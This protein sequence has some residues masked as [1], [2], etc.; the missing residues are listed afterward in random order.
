M[1]PRSLNIFFPFLKKKERTGWRGRCHRWLTLLGP[2]WRSSPVR[3][4]IQ[5]VC[6]ALFFYFF[7]F[8]CWPYA[9]HFTSTTFSDKEWMPVDSFLLIDPLVGLSTV[10]AGKVLNWGTLVW[11]VGVVALCLLIPRG[12]CG[13]L[14]PLGTLI[15]GF[16]WLI[17][18]HFRKLH[19][20]EPRGGWVHFKYY[21]LVAVL[22]SSVF[23]VLTSGFF[24]A[25]PV[26][27]RGV[28]FTG[29][30]LQ[31]GLIKGWEN[32]GPA[33]WTMYLSVAMAAGVFLLSLLGKRF[34]CRYAC[35]S[36]ALLS[37]FN[38]FRV[39][40][41]KVES[42]CIHCDRC[43]EICPFAAIKEDF[44]TRTSDCTLCQS[45]GGV[46][47]TDAIK[48]VP[49][50][51][52]INLKI[53]DDPPV[54]PRPLSRR[55]FMAAGAMGVAAAAATPI[56]GRAKNRDLPLRPP[57]SVPEREFLDLCIRCGECFNVCPGPVLHPAG[58][59]HGLESLWTPVAVPS[60]AGCH[61]DC[62]FCTQ[63]CPTGAIQPLEI[64]VKRKVH[65]GLAIMNTET[66]LPFDDEGREDCDDCYQECVD[67][68]YNAIE[69]RTLKF[70]LNPPPPAGVFSDE[71]IEQMSSIHAPFVNADACVGCGIC[72]YRCHTKYVKQIGRLNQSAIIVKALKEHRAL[73]FPERPEDLPA[74]GTTS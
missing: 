8:T 69:M 30:R 3:R 66:C 29:G 12:F 46:C 51:N 47:P 13:F 58:L 68:G 37:F 64:E 43:V 61:Q 26:L 25:I 63:V 73:K 20:E 14:C 5:V 27:T 9:E 52:L 45:C 60:H 62:S 74:P 7:F 54:K 31:L 17:G 10:L 48:F 41:R 35:P 38:L 36:G 28:L 6:L 42:T 33:G 22:M 57:G 16:D 67:A 19:L 50:G 34:W 70:D 49:R 24:S 44:T 23:G 55:G 4:V 1:I 65:M 59:E 72:E 71:E 21:L 15:D 32:V 53:N 2:V 40:E 56:H 18:R 11:M 39:S